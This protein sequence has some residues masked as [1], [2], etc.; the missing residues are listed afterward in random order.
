MDSKTFMRK[1]WTA[2]IL[3]M[4]LMSIIGLSFTPGTFAEQHTGMA[5]LSNRPM[6]NLWITN[7]TVYQLEA[8]GDLL[9]IRGGFDRVG[10]H[11][12]LAVPFHT[13]DGTLLPD[14]P[15]VDGDLNAEVRAIAPDGE[16]GWYI[17]GNFTTVNGTSW[18]NLAHVRADYSL[19]PNWK[20]DPNGPVYALA[21]SD[22]IL[23]IGGAFTA[24]G[25]QDRQ[26]L[27]ALNTATGEVTDWNPAADDDARALAVSGNTLY[28]GGS[29]QQIGGEPRPYAAALNRTTGQVL[30]WN[31]L[32]DGPVF[33]LVVS[34]T[35]VYA[36]GYFSEIGWSDR[37]SIAALDAITGQ[38]LNWAVGLSGSHPTVYA[39]AVSGNTV[40]VGGYFEKS[41]CPSLVFLDARTGSTQQCPGVVMGTDIESVYALALGDD[42]LYV[43][44]R[45]TGIAGQ[46]RT[47]LAALDASTGTAREW[48]P[49]PNCPVRALALS[50]DTLYAGGCLRSAAMLRRDDGLA[51]IHI[52]T[53]QPA[54]W[55]PPEIQ[56]GGVGAFVISGTTLYIGGDFSSVGGQPRDGLAA[57]DLVTGEVADWNPLPLH[58]VY[59]TIQTMARYGNTLYLGG[60]FMITGDQERYRL[61]AVDTVTGELLPWAPRA[62]YPVRAMVVSGDRLYVGGE[63]TTINDQRHECLA[64]FD[65]TTGQLLPW[66]PVQG[67]GYIDGVKALTV[68]NNLLYVG[69]NFDTM[70]GQERKGLAAIDLHTREVTSWNPHSDGVVWAV[71]VS[72]DTV[73]VGG[74]FRN[75]GGQPRNR[76]AALDAITGRANAWNPSLSY[77]PYALAVVGNSLYVGGDVYFVGTQSRYYLAGFGPQNGPYSADVSIAKTDARDFAFPYASHTY[78]LTVS[79]AGP[80]PAGVVVTDFF[81]VAFTDAFWFCHEG[82]FSRCTLYG[83]AGNI[84]TTLTV[85]PGDSVTIFA[86]GRIPYTATGTLVNTATVIP[87]PGVED[88]NPNNNSA[89]DLTVIGAPYQTYLPLVLCRR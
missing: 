81:P 23:Y 50:G 37:T 35:T 63:F 29:F 89:T 33:A 68:S 58:Q 36:G 45:F 82:A 31:P 38:A 59:D 70:D 75:I 53:G 6:E 76:L 84:S 69:G 14:F 22:K 24:I 8:V 9:Y 3:L 46:P 72:G 85:G 40:Y 34:G 66:N 80:D 77:R 83:V 19:D 44:G 17:G 71:E 87:P 48:D 7:G 61:A 74:D 11:T 12:G 65:L 52:P 4:I 67:C 13:S 51:A 18:L 86:Q 49:A 28:V 10:P 25:G 16:G 54:A 5:D 88:P 43:G 47:H 15:Q 27:A 39:L 57:I 1:A 20:P 26:R 30:D 73:L 78:T 55:T 21:L 60:S 32:S 42:T 62:N 79:N 56:G 2:L 64:A 41:G